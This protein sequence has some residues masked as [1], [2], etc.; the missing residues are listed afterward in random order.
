MRLW[1]AKRSEV[2]VRE[3]IATQLLL[4]ILSE[5]L[6]AG[7]RLPSTRSLARRLRVHSNTVSAAYR[8]LTRRGWIVLRRGSGVYVRSRRDPATADRSLELDRLIANFIRST[9]DRGFAQEEI[10]TRLKQWLERQPPHYLL[11]IEP[12]EE[13]RHILA[14]EIEE[15]TGF[16]VRALSPEECSD[17]TSWLGAAPVCLFNK[18]E[19]I[20]S[21]LP[22]LDVTVV[23]HP[24]SALASLEEQT[25]FRPDAM[26]AVVSAWP[27][28][29]KW[30]RTVLVAAGLPADAIIA[31]NP[32]EPYW[33][34]GLRAA[35]AVI[36][37][38][39]SASLIPPG[40]RI[41]TFRLISDPSIAEL[42]ELTETL[43]GSPL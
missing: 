5:E 35:T 21:A 15:A 22:S 24:R 30:T 9:R 39:A 13:L 42:R 41:H 18:L 26:I 27:E 20:Q 33:R 2:P 37:D 23:L 1:V 32:R 14:R 43:K 16:P 10:Q 36:A 6:R 31:S 25:P 40:H 11:V 4:A 3:Q 38:V 7:Q 19:E 28:F 34:R 17:E 29:I 8:D 12:D